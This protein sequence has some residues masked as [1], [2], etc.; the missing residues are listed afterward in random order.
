M[1]NFTA[2]KIEVE[3]VFKIFRFRVVRESRSCYLEDYI[4]NKEDR[5]VHPLEQRRAR[6][7]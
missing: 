1:A 7:A 2:L 6:G 3:T 5:D 4:M